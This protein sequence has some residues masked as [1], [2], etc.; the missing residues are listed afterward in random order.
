MGEEK[1][2]RTSV[3]RKASNAVTLGAPGPIYLM[4]QVSGS[5]EASNA[6]TLG[7]PGPIYLM[8]QVTGGQD[9]R[10]AS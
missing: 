4:G 7:A 3:K 2:A 8:G 5:Q 10:K 9:R 1:Q 6:V